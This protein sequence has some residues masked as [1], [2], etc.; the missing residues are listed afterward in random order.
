M[1]KILYALLFILLFISC[2]KPPEPDGDIADTVTGKYLF[3]HVD[4]FLGV[5]S[6]YTVVWT[7]TKSSDN[8]VILKHEIVEKIIGS[9]PNG[10]K[11]SDPFSGTI[12][13]IKIINSGR[14]KVD[15]VVDFTFDGVKEKTQLYIAGV[16]SGNNLNVN[17]KQTTHSDNVTLSE[18]FVFEKQ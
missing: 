11:P 13:G 2:N 8:E 7:I 15:Q 4:R 9:N 18:T 17:L 14:L 6:E 5:D 1:K 12:T 3:V 16:V 10:Y